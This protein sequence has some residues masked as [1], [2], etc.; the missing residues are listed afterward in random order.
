MLYRYLDQ[1]DARH[2]GAV[3]IALA[4]FQDAHASAVALH[5]ARGNV[6]HEFVGHFFVVEIRLNLADLVQR[7]CVTRLGF[8]GLRDETL[9]NRT[10]GLGLGLGGLDALGSKQ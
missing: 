3:T 6:L 8:F 1:F 9:G 2:W 4:K 7:C 5:V 10:L